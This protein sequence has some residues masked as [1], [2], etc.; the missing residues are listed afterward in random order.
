MQ[1]GQN[2]QVGTVYQ[3]L[4]NSIASA[5]LTTQN[6]NDVDNWRR[7]SYQ[8]S[9]QVQVA[10]DHTAGGTA[11]SVYRYLG[12]PGE[13]D[14]STT[15]FN[16]SA[17]ALVTDFTSINAMAQFGDININEVS[18]DLNVDQITASNGDVSLHAAGSIAV[19][20][21]SASSWH[22]GEVDGGSIELIAAQGGIGNSESR[23]LSLDTGSTVADLL[24]ASANTSIY[25]E[26]RSGDLRL[27]GTNENPAEGELPTTGVVSALG[28]VYINV[29]SGSLIDGDNQS[30]VD[31]RTADQLRNGVWADLGLIN[32][33]D[34]T[35][36]IGDLVPNGQDGSTGSYSVNVDAEDANKI[37]FSE[38]G[39]SDALFLSATTNAKSLHRIY[40]DLDGDGS[41]GDYDYITLDASDSGIDSATNSAVLPQGHGLVTGDTVEYQMWTGAQ[42]KI[43]RTVEDFGAITEA[44]Y[45]AYWQYRSRFV[46]YD[47]TASLS[48]SATGGTFKLQQTVEGVTTQ[49]EAIAFDVSADTLRDQ[50]ATLT[51]LAVND[52]VVSGTA[53]DWS[54]NFND[55]SGVITESQLQLV[56]QKLVEQN[57]VIGFA[58][59][60]IQVEDQSTWSY[61]YADTQAIVIEGAER[62]FYEDLGWT[63]A[64]ILT[65]ETKR[66]AEYHG[67]HTRFG[68]TGDTYNESYRY[69][70]SDEQVTAVTGTIK[71]WSEAELLNLIGSGL[72]MPVTDT[73]ASIES[74]N[75]TAD[76]GDVVLSAVNTGAGNANVGAS[77]GSAIITVGSNFTADERQ[78][79]AAAE[80]ADI[81]FLSALPSAL[82]NLQFIHNSNTVAGTVDHSPQDQ[83]TRF[84]G[85]SWSSVAG[86]AFAE[87]MQIQVYGNSDNANDNGSF[88]TIASLSADTI[89]LITG[90]TLAAEI[91]ADVAIASIIPSL[92]VVID[93]NVTINVAANSITRLSGSW[94]DS[95]LIA[96]QV[97]QLS[98]KV[99][100]ETTNSDVIR[101]DAVVQSVS[102]GVLTIESNDQL[103]AINNSENVLNL[104]YANTVNFIRVDLRDDIDL[105]AGGMINVNA[106]NN[107]FLGSENDLRIGTIV[108]GEAVRIKTGMGIINASVDGASATNVQSGDLVLEAATSSIGGDSAAERFYVDL[109]TNTNTNTDAILTLRASGDVYVTERTGN[110]NLGTLYSQS[111]SINLTTLD[112][113]IVDGLDHDYANIVASTAIRLVANGGSVGEMSVVNG[114]SIVTDYVEF[115]LSSDGYIDINASEDVALKQVVGNMNVKLVEAGGDVDLWASLAILDTIDS[116]GSTVT[117]VGAGNSAALGLADV[118]GENVSLHA[119]LGTIGISGQDFDVDSDAGSN[120]TDHGVLTTSSNQNSYIIETAGDLYLRSVGTTGTQGT[121]TAYI[122]SRAAIFNGHIDLAASNVSAGLTQLYAVGNIGSSNKRL[123]TTVGQLEGNSTEGEVWLTNTGHLIVEA[124]TGTQGLSAK[125]NVNLITNSPLTVADDIVS[126]E[127]F[128]ILTASEDPGAG[129]DLTIEAGVLINST[130]GTVTLRAGDNISIATGA[131]ITAFT[132]LLIEG[133][134]ESDDAGVGS[135]IDVQGNLAAVTITINGGADNDVINLNG[136]LRDTNSA[137]DADVGVITIAGGEGNDTI[138]LDAN[139]IT[140]RTFITGNAGDDDISVTRLHTRLEALDLDGGEGQDDYYIETTNIDVN[141]DNA[142]YLINVLDSGAN[143]NDYDQL[144]VDGTSTEDLFLIREN[145]IARMHGTSLDYFNNPAVERINYNGNINGNATQTFDAEAKVSGVVTSGIIINTLAGDDEIFFDDTG[146]TFTVNAGDDQDTFQV[147]QIFGALPSDLSDPNDAISTTAVT[148]GFLSFGT[149]HV[150]TLNGGDE[151]GAG[152]QFSVY[153]NKALLFLNGGDGDDNFELRA[154]LI[155]GSVLS[156]VNGGEGNNTIEYNLNA[157]VRIDGGNG[158][159]TVTLIGTEADDVVLLNANGF[160]GA[161]VTADIT[162]VEFIELDLLQG[163]DTFYIQGSEAGVVYTLIGGSGS[164]DFIITG[165]VL[166]NVVVNEDITVDETIGTID[167]PIIIE[168]GNAERDRSLRIAVMLPEETPAIP[169]YIGD[170]TREHSHTDRLTI[171]RD[172]KSDAEFISVAATPSDAAQEASGMTRVS[173]IDQASI[174]F[175]GIDIFE[176]LLGEGNDEA[177]IDVA[178]HSITTTFDIVGSNTLKNLGGEWFEAGYRIGDT[179]FITGSDNYDGSYSIAEMSSDGATITLDGAS[180]NND[181]DL[182]FTVTRA[183]PLMLIHGGGNQSL[184]SGEMGGDTITVTGSGYSDGSNSVPLII[185]GDTTQDGSRY[186]DDPV[187]PTTSAA[188]AFASAGNDVINASAATAGVVIYGGAG[189]DTLTGSQAS[190]VILGG[191]GNDTI[192]GLT[193]A[194]HLY[195]DSGLNLHVDIDNFNQRASQVENYGP[196]TIEGRISLRTDISQSIIEIVT[197]DSSDNAVKDSLVVGNDVINAGG[198]NDIAFGDHGVIERITNSYPNDFLLFSTENVNRIYSTVNTVGGD[199]T[200]NAGDGNNTVVGGRGNDIITS[201]NGIDIVAGDNIIITLD[202]NIPT[203]MTPADDIAGNDVINLGAGGAFV[204]AGAGDDEVTNA[205]GNSVII[206]DQGT[207]NFAANGLYANAFT[208]DVDVVGND[209]LIG[210]SDSDVIFGGA[211]SDRIMGSAGNDFLVGDAGMITRDE[212]LVTLES[213]STS[214]DDGSVP[215]AIGF[216][217]GDNDLL[218]GGLDNDFM[219]GGLSMSDGSSISGIFKDDIKDDIFVGDLSE[220]IIIGEYAR[221]RLTID[222]DQKVTGI[223][224]I[225]TLGQG[226]LDLIRVAQ[227]ALY[228]AASLTTGSL[229]TAKVDSLLTS[230]GLAMPTAGSSTEYRLGRLR[231]IGLWRSIIYDFFK[232]SC[233][234][235]SA[236]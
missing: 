82:N 13:L 91:G 139:E 217:T 203:M 186:N 234:S 58:T 190:D 199:D 148:S 2:G 152:D 31:T 193:G 155:A 130:L 26:E 62:T 113:S 115:Q 119:E 16:S 114:E 50:L 197:V 168:G 84:D 23:R 11:G 204:I 73:Q 128:I 166:A 6:Y 111:G 48:Y 122:L 125:G 74:I 25:I 134:F 95:A 98:Y 161:G 32:I 165:D 210:G 121:E 86:G 42:A 232:S 9:D 96:G 27:M 137:T 44:E 56:E 191:T 201:G 30:K 14:L 181:G 225:V 180:F 194:D 172:H 189:N 97:I 29:L 212:S 37:Y 20:Q 195:G 70:L 176:M 207:I 4:G 184:A 77:T 60:V 163:N 89:T 40:F 174:D 160:F 45:D 22:E 17:W 46:T 65:L 158:T 221:M 157:L 170:P 218:D 120:T 1:A 35:A 18:G 100:S 55:A 15:N 135:I 88:Y 52:V 223:E 5:N 227:Q 90:D 233:S 219:I 145:Y 178:P 87:G 224:S 183:L 140:G 236:N 131:N 220:D 141:G 101:F 214:S 143:A 21:Q 39:S 68:S 126:D 71:V 142:D 80:R 188:R 57:L 202:N 83:I 206:G 66:T 85:V 196:V 185:F 198:G 41:V 153:S 8:G 211:G 49:T 149:S 171:F 133:D 151:V 102:A 81:S 235:I 159:D 205:A 64:E 124:I 110:I 54:V 209:I 69:V 192:F 117:S 59:L 164:D 154:F 47:E 129:D 3:Y 173:G 19:A 109:N 108:A 169:L 127:G 231:Y 24:V 177:T 213:I 123:Q 106:D 105:N 36:N 51:G 104:T 75:I 92:S 28:D 187:N 67:L 226:P 99:E 34:V 33:I 103:R 61:P 222:A 72:V 7:M 144:V 53:G 216:F 79:L 43:K 156:S 229:S 162:N 138:N 93:T 118:I 132:D 76:N 116:D 12:G 112:G 147:G 230:N 228:T 10:A 215:E 94:L 78:I 150:V 182:A 146:T 208:G 136:S 38:V 175:A 63:P 167:G 179:V 200:I 107:V